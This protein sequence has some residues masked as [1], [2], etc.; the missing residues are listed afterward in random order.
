MTADRERLHVPGA[1]SQPELWAHSVSEEPDAAASGCPTSSGRPEQRA[2]LTRSFPN[3]ISCEGA[4]L[5]WL[6]QMRCGTVSHAR[7]RAV[8]SISYI[9]LTNC[10]ARKRS[11]AEALR[12]PSTSDVGTLHGEVLRW[13]RALAAHEPQMPV[14]T[15]YVG[16]SI[17]EA[18]RICDHLGADLWVAS[19]GAGLVHADD[20]LAPYDVT[21]S[22]GK[23]SLHVLL[24]R[25]G[26]TP[27]EWWRA[28]R[29]RCSLAQLLQSTPNAMLLAALPASY[30]QLIAADLS[31]LKDSELARVRIFTSS[32][33]AEVLGGDLAAAVMPYDERLEDIA[34]YRGTRADFPQRA[35]R[36]FVEALN[37]HTLDQ[38]AGRLAVSKS[39]QR[40]PWPK[41]TARRRADDD[42]IKELIRREW[43]RTGGRCSVMLRWVR[44]NALVSCEQSRFSQ[45]WRAVR[46]ERQV[47]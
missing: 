3:A 5:F 26:A 32:V 23:E 17:A 22:G 28:L 14:R 45:L 31:E 7:T 39:L 46:S 30:V 37:G 34:Q 29:G 9:V 27:S 47:R 43:V 12:L 41:V 44:D 21:A 19:A 16:R 2:R 11:G 35:L 42:E 15:L 10:T 25:L 1:F 18:K 20:N 8:S 33:G 38:A 13:K 6:L 40:R 36:H 4:Q 24:Q